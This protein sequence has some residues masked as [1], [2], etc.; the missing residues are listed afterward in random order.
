MR[1]STKRFLA[2]AIQLSMTSSVVLIGCDAPPA[3]A[4]EI[5]LLGLSDAGNRILLDAGKQGAVDGGT[6]KPAGEIIGSG[7]RCGLLRDRFPL[8]FEEESLKENTLYRVSLTST[9]GDDPD[10]LIYRA[11]EPNYAVYVARALGGDEVWL[12]GLAD[13]TWIAEVTSPFGDCESYQLSVQATTLDDDPRGFIRLTGSVSYEDRVYDESGFTGEL[14]GLPARGVQVDL[15]DEAQKTLASTT[16][17]AQGRFD[18]SVPLRAEQRVQLRALAVLEAFSQWSRVRD[19]GNPASVYALESELFAADSAPIFS[20]LAEAA[21]TGGAFNIL[22]ATYAGYE[23]IHTHS[24]QLAPRLTYSWQR[25][26]P[27]NC[28]SCYSN[29]RISLGGQFEDPDEYDDDIVLHEFGHYFA[30]HYAPDD[31]PG[32]SHRDNRVEPRLAWGEG[33]A[34]FFSSMVRHDPRVVDNYIDEVRFTDLEKVELNGESLGDLFG[35][36]DDTLEG[37]LREEIVGGLL[38]DAFDDGI[39]EEHDEMHLGEEGVMNIL[40]QPLDANETDVGVRGVDLAD[41]LLGG[42]C[43]APETAAASEAL[44]LERALPWPEIGAQ[45]CAQK[46][47]RSQPNLSFSPNAFSKSAQSKMLSVETEVP[48]LVYYGLLTP[49]GSFLEQGNVW[50]DLLCALPYSTEQAVFIKATLAGENAWRTYI[51][52]SKHSLFRGGSSFVVDDG[53]DGK[54]GHLRVWQAKPR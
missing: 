38:W 20:P 28:G 2:L 34:Y 36:S 49:S 54:V 21:E 13:D 11:S 44:V 46:T 1:R 48:A 32:G 53:R 52:W 9:A 33:L 43:Y 45:H 24:T 18:F 30:E 22:D 40:L 17:D 14:E 12:E 15:I 5:P 47:L 50:C 35:S 37:D 26:Q 25:A 6:A 39:N 27:F 4:P 42:Y 10:L 7:E 51:P 19:R 41:W 8:R 31:S 16:T 3:E 29:S 23:L